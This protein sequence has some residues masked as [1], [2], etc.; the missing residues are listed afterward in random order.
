MQK[1]ALAVAVAFAVIGF[2]W[3]TVEARG[4][5]SGGHGSS[6][7]GGHYVNPSIGNHYTHHKVT[8]TFMHELS[9]RPANTVFGIEIDGRRNSR[10]G[11]NSIAEGE[12]AATGLVAQGRKVAIFDLVTGR[13]IKH[14]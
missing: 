9:P 7:K 1:I 2:A 4:Y 5:Y 11:F 6:H 10:R 13:I 14:L 3:N 12:Q 8:D